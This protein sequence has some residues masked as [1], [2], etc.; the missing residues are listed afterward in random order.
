MAFVP[1]DI[2]AKKILYSAEEAWGF[3]PGGNETGIIVYALPEPARLRIEA[4]GTMWLDQLPGSGKDWPGHYR[5]WRETP[6]DPNVRGAFDIWSMEA[7]LETCGHG[8]G[9]AAYMFRYGFCIAFDREIERIANNVLSNT[10]SYYAFG[11]IGMLLI[12]PTENLIIYA[13]NG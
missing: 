5:N 3:G 9:L 8:A 11:R 4:E 12:I 10:G 6:F 7:R 13:Y 2:D 1:P